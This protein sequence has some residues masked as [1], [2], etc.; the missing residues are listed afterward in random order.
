VVSLFK[1]RSPVTVIWLFLLSIIVH[2]HLFV[3]FSGL[4]VTKNDGFLSIWLND[5]FATLSFPLLIFIYHAIVVLEALRLNYLFTDH[6]MYSKQNNLVAMVYILLSGVFTVWTNITPA[7]LDNFLVIWLFAK[8]VKLYSSPNAKTL[9]FNIGLIIGVSILLYQPSALLIL[10]AF[11]GLM[12][13]RPFAFREWMVLLMGVICPF[14]FLASW[15]YLTDRI[16]LFLNYIP[17]WGFNLPVS[18]ASVFFFVT[19]GL[20]IV[21]LIIGLFYWQHENRR[22]LIQVRKNWVVLLVM[23]LIMLPVPFINQGAGIESLFLW[24][25]P[26][27]PFIAKGFLGPKRNFLPNLMFWSLLAIGILKNWEIVK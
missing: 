20:V 3:H 11:F 24:I 8:I 15:L 10:V 19:I 2:S 21:I 13:L 7:L 17:D 1:D 27:S 12:V 18:Q 22:L 23:L 6:R 14:Y 4:V 26:A 25:V 16:K 5:Y 9:L